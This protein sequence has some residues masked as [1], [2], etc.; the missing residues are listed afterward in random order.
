MRTWYLYVDDLR[1]CPSTNSNYIVVTCR[2]YESAIDT[3][4]YLSTTNQPFVL[5]LDHDL[6]GNKTGYDICKFIVENKLVQCERVKLHSMNVVGMA[7]MRQLLSHYGYN[8]ER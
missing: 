7:N 8:C 5:D 6:G 3:I 1:N 2:T 4:K